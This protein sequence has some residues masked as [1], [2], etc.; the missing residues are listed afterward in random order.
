MASENPYEP[1]TPDPSDAERDDAP[2]KITFVTFG[3]YL[4]VAFIPVLLVLLG[5][6]I[7]AI[8]L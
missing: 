7:N 4:L 1:P 2:L 8:G 6:L 3:V 5:F